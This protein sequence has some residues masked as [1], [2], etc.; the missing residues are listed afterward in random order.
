MPRRF[1]RDAQDTY[2]GYT[3]FQARI[4]PAVPAQYLAWYGLPW[5]QKPIVNRRLGH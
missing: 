5:Y 1:A 3:I 2:N 4:A